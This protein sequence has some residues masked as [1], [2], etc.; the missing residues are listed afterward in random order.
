MFQKG[1]QDW[2][3]WKEAMIKAVVD[4]QITEGCAKGS[5]DPEKDPWGDSG[6]R[7]YSTALCTLCLEVFYRYDSILGAR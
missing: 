7:V 6:G 3:V 5:W 4:H 1:G 2:K